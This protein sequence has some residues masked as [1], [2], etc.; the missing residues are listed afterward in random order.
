[1]KGGLLVLTSFVLLTTAGV[2]GQQDKLI[3]HFMYDKM[4]LNPGATGMGMSDGFCGT[5]IYRNQWDK[6]N[7]APNS[8]VLNLEGSLSRI[9]P[10]LK[11]FGLSFYHDAIG[12][13]RQ[14]NLVLN[15][16]FHQDLSAVNGVLGVG[17]G[18]GFT[19]LGMTPDWVPPT[20]V[21][22]PSLPTAFSATKLDLNFGV[23][24][25][26]NDDWYVGVS[27]THLSASTL[28]DA[29]VTPAPVW[30]YTSARHYYVMGGW[31]RTNTWGGDLDLNAVYRTDLVKSS[32]EISARYIR[33]LSREHKFYG[34]LGFRFIE[35]VP[36]M[37]GYKGDLGG[38][39]F[40]DAGYSYDVSTN[41][42]SSI[43]RG[44]HEMMVKFC[45]YLPPVPIQKSKHPRW[46]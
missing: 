8:A 25:R 10:L 1:M 37:L 36:I 43:S 9:H 24:F 32:A 31:N 38:G 6:V 7:G 13:T 28:T 12:F 23:Y 42:L 26:S 39:N 20:G 17:I 40:I 34:G 2:F 16:S 14:N 35:S 19:N 4:S 45:H 3:T 41:K 44:T 27:S 21:F 15:Y 30:G 46:L 11:G 18:A 22:D 5:L 33:T 29:T